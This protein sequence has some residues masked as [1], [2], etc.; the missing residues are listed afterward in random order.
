MLMLASRGI[1][2]LWEDRKQTQK[3]KAYFIIIF[4]FKAY[5]IMSHIT[6]SQC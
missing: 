3:V 6:K 4:F 2:S 5:F 1:Q